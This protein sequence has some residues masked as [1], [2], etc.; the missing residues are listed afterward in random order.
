MIYLVTNLIRVRNK[1]KRRVIVIKTNYIEITNSDGTT[2]N[3]PVHD[4]T[5]YKGMLIK[6]KLLDCLINFIKDVEYSIE[7]NSILMNKI[8]DGEKT[9]V[10]IENLLEDKSILENKLYK[11]NQLLEV[12]K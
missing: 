4:N 9:D 10:T 7:I 11:A 8:N 2:Y 1:I 12:I 6:N 3:A 5:N